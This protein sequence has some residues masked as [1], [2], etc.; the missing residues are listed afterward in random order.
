MTS[1]PEQHLTCPA[2][3][4]EITLEVHGRAYCQPCQLE[5]LPTSPQGAAGDETTAGPALPSS[6]APAL[7]SSAPTAPQEAA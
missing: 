5:M 7:S 1:Q 2:C 4:H 3:R 6:E